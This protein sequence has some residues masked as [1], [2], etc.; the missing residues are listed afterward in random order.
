MTDANKT[1]IGGTHYKKK[2]I[3]KEMVPEGGLDPWD[4]FHLWGLDYFTATAVKYITRWEDK[5]GKAD[6][7]K[8]IHFLQKRIELENRRS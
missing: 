5:G 6:L 8:A 2:H 7:E 3:T 4:V 1:Q